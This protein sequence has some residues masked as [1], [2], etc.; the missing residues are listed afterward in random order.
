ML[1]AATNAY[2]LDGAS[3]HNHEVIQAGSGAQHGDLHF[4]VG[5]GNS[6]YSLRLIC[7]QRY[8]H[9]VYVDLTDEVLSEQM[10]LCDFLVDNGLPF[11]VCK[12]PVPSEPF[13]SFNW[14]DTNYRLVIFNWIDGDHRT[15]PTPEMALKAGSLARIFHDISIGF[16]STVLPR[17]NHIDGSKKWLSLIRDH[18]SYC[19]LDQACKHLIETYLS[20][21]EDHIA[22][23]TTDNFQ[24]KDKIV[25]FDLTFLNVLWD[26]NYNICGVVDFEK[27]Q[28]SER[29]Q[30][31]AWL[32][33]TYARIGEMGADDWSGDLASSVLNGYRADEVLDDEDYGR[34]PSLT[35]L[36]GCLHAN[37]IHQ[38]LEILSQQ[39]G[40]QFQLE[41]HLDRYSIRG[42]RL[43]AVFE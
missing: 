19:L 41:R 29:T 14:N 24:N 11:M 18:E 39:N 27:S 9:D 8:T 40:A 42:N 25:Q 1:I 43:L 6:S 30:N 28:Y 15:E 16:A 36:S 23:A 10:R 35:W 21:A 33:K 38:T 5:I 37:F 13:V 4:K 3:L 34:L 17:T 32:I 7:S 22:K 26:E 2:G 20:Q 31:L 12:L